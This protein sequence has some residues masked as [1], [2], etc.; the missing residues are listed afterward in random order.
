MDALLFPDAQ[1]RGPVAHAGV[2]ALR[3]PLDEAMRLSRLGRRL[4][5]RPG[6]PLASEP[7]VLGDR[8]GQEQ[9]FLQHPG[10]LPAQGVPIES[11][12]VEPAPP[13]PPLVRL[14][15][16][17]DELQQRGL[18]RTAGAD[19]GDDLAGFDAQVEPVQH[20]PAGFVREADPVELQRD[21]GIGAGRGRST[22]GRKRRV[23]PL[24]HPLRAGLGRGDRATQV[25]QLVQGFIELRQIGQEDH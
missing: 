2:V 22:G 6:R 20:R 7:D 12:Q 23:E 25:R 13:D 24:E 3:Q 16:P 15:E 5:L 17:W 9:G 11:L 4:D 10:D 21:A 14:Q 1:S 19:E 18:A 8:R